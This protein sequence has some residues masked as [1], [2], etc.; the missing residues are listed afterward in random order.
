[1]PEAH[2]LSAIARWKKVPK[3]QK[4]LLGKTLAIA[5]WKK[6]SKKKRKEISKKLVLAR[7]NK[8]VDKDPPLRIKE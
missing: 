6:V 5:R 3:K 1:M 2:R 8:K 7:G 4:S